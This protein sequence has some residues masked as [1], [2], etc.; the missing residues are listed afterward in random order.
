MST[1]IFVKPTKDY[2]RDLDI[3]KHYIDQSATYLS[4]VNNVPYEVA[5]N[6]IKKQ[7][8]KEGKFAFNPP[9]VIYTDKN[10][11]GDKIEKRSNMYS[12]LKESIDRKNL[13]SPTLTTYKNID[14]EESMFNGFI[15]D[16][17]K[18]RGSF[19]KLEA[20]AKVE[21]N[22]NA[23]NY[24]GKLQESVKQSNNSFSGALALNSIGLANPSGHPTLTST[25]RTSTA[26]GG[27]HIERFVSGNRHYFHPDVV[28]GNILSIIQN[29]DYDKVKHVIEKFNLVIPTAEQ[30]LIAIKRCTDQ[31]WKSK[32]AQDKIDR[33]V[34]KL[35][36][37]ERA[38]YLYTG[39]F[40]SLRLLNENVI[41]TFVTSMSLKETEVKIEVPLELIKN[42]S[43][44]TVILA[45][46][47]CSKETCDIGK[48]YSR[49]SEKD[50]N[51][52]AAT[53]NNIDK[54]VVAYADLITTFWSTSN[55]LPNVSYM[56]DSIRQSL[57]GGD[58]DS[59]IYTVQEWVQWFKGD[60]KYDET[61]IAVGASIVF[62][63]DNTLVNV[64]AVMS[65]NMGIHKDSLF[66]ISMKN[67]FRFNIFVPTQG[68]KHYFA[69]IGQ[70]EGA[71]YL[72]T[73]L[74]IKGVHLKNSSSPEEIIKA[75]ENMMRDIIA[76]YKRDGTISAKKY[77]RLVRDQEMNIIDSIKKGE[78]K[79]L[80]TSK[81]KSSDAYKGESTESPYKQHTFWNATFGL[82]YGKV[83][84]PPYDTVKLNLTTD[85][86][87]R[88]KQWIATMENKKLATNLEKWLKDNG[89]NT[90]GTIQIPLFA[91]A[92]GLPKE[93]TDI[94]DYSSIVLDICKIFY[95]VLETLGIY[96][97]S[98][99][100][101]P[102]MVMDVFID[103]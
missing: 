81:I 32:S 67:E 87:T 101:S 82:A 72:N 92:K 44:N 10:E 70:K 84:E 48:D 103:N 3:I 74:E 79:Y 52:L 18:K 47:I 34:T 24:N 33:L 57:L 73:E 27:A 1:N 28:I 31:Y 100:Q 38:A 95:L 6:F 59:C 45:H 46:Q 69:D 20:K 54:T 16:N 41:R 30:V 60:L 5:V 61:L 65:A 102:K 7:L 55:L 15:D 93:L 97:N 68:G 66:K 14:E 50:L 88:F 2:K 86:S 99:M 89:R 91:L 17:I 23:K 26:N 39:D 29:T 4:K 35:S 85:N 11:H 25:C 71:E 98:K 13:I 42:A 76:D 80:R 63:V 77:L 9:G 51:T 36:G 90:I 58:T 19:K 64:L 43:N 75:G 53:M 96:V 37:L 8:G 78:W 83:P 94:V 56:P 62:F 21:K 12:Y 22:N 40:Y 49:L